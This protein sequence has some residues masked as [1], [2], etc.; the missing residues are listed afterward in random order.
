MQLTVTLDNCARCGRP[1]LPGEPVM[2]SASVDIVS[3]RIV[4]SPVR[5]E[6]LKG[7]CPIGDQ[8]LA[9]PGP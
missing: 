4:S 8:A 5:S 7:M 9:G 3:K 6:H 1:I 2:Q